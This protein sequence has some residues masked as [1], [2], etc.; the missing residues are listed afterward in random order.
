MGRWFCVAY[1]VGMY[2]YE[3]VLYSL[4]YRGIE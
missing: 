2:L 3:Y 4:G 1:Y